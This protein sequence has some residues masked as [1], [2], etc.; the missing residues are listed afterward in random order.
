VRQRYGW[1]CATR[2][3]TAVRSAVVGSAPAWHLP[4][5]NARAEEIAEHVSSH[6]AWLFSLLAGSLLLL[7]SNL[8]TTTTA[9]WPQPQGSTQMLFK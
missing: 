6:G 8:P 4:G 1:P 2:G 3:S 9:A 7:E 5:T